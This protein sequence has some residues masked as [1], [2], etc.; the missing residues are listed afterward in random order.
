M[1]LI[2]LRIRNI[3]KLKQLTL[4]E[5]AK[6]IISVPYL[7]NIENGVKVASFETLMHI[8]KRLEIP[9]EALLIGNEDLNKELLQE[10]KQIFE[11]LVFSNTKE[12]EA[13]LNKIAASVDL[14]CESPVI[15]LSFYWLQ[16]GF[17]Y[18]IWEFSKARDIEEKY[19][20][21]NEKRVVE[22]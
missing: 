19:L 7:A 2:G 13:R 3:R 6:G 21:S 15:E 1:D 20:N 18:K 17:Y 11:L 5:A 4:K 16:A 14:L 8:A 9:E 12:V 10:L 22:S